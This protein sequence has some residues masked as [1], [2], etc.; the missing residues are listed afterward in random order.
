[1]LPVRRLHVVETL[2]PQYGMPDPHDNFRPWQQFAPFAHL[3]DTFQAA[4]TFNPSQWFRVI[5]IVL[6]WKQNIRV[7][8]LIFKWRTP[9]TDRHWS[10]RLC[11]ICI[12]RRCP[13]LGEPYIYIYI[14]IYI[15]V[16]VC[17]CVYRDIVNAFESKA[18]K[19]KRQK[20]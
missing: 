1:M 9:I 11:Q 2:E 13:A 4:G 7:V 12:H 17:V 19:K 14:Y 6:S 5:R 20:I 10:H 3:A 18:K 15:C 16:R 8:D